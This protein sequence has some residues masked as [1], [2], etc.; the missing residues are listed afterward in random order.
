[1]YDV[2]GKYEDYLLSKVNYKDN[3]LFKRIMDKLFHTKYVPYM[4]LDVNR[5]EDGLSLRIGYTMDHSLPPE[6]LDRELGTECTVL[7]MMVALAIRCELDVAGDPTGDDRTAHWFDVMIESMGLNQYTDNFYNVDSVASIIWKM[8]NHDYLPNGEGGLFK[9]P[10][11]TGF[12]MTKI[13]TW[14]QMNAYIT[15][16][17]G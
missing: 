4:G 13:E 12:D 11:G 16:V 14:S 5:G 2:V 15:V 6:Y 8:Q 7:E 10:E 17:E 3:L 1:M 9:I